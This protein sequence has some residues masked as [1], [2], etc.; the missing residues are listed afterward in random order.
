MQIQNYE[1]LKLGSE[2]FQE[3]RDSFDVLLQ[4]LFKKMEDNNG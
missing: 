4:K 1:E 2:M 3:I